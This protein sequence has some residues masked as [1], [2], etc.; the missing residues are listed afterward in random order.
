MDIFVQDRKLNISAAYFKPGFAFGGSC[1]PKDLRAINYKAKT[2]DLDI[3]LFRSILPSN[4]VHVDRAIDMVQS[5]GSKNVSILGLS[6]KAGTD[7]LRESPIVEMTERLLGKGYDIKIFDRNV[8]LAQLTGAN[9]DYLLNHV[10]HIS[11][12]LVED[13]QEVLS[14]GQTVVIANPAKE[15]ID[16]VKQVTEKQRIIDLVRLFKDIPTSKNYEGIG[17]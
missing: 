12:L 16:I 9:K 6:F 15:F 11:N 7:D 3:P 1:L 17:W 10:P 4:R 5:A 2:L 14:H 8:R 13:V